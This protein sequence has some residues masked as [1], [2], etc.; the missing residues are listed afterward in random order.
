MLGS[1]VG[2]RVGFLRGREAVRTRSSFSPLLFSFSFPSLFLLRLFARNP[3]STLPNP[4]VPHISVAH[5]P[6]STFPTKTP[7][8]PCAP[9]GSPPTNTYPLPFFCPN[10]QTPNPPL[11]IQLRVSIPLE[12]AA[13][14]RGEKTQRKSPRPTSWE[15]SNIGGAWLNGC[16]TRRGGFRFETVGWEREVCSGGWERGDSKHTSRG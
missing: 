9:S 7:A 11:A 15:L 14:G 3:L 8:T 5:L 2:G 13:T 12:G 10:S 6:P 16:C 4:P 1:N